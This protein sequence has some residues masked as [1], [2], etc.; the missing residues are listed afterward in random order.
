LKKIGIVTIGQSP[1]DDIIPEMR[2]V[3]GRNVEILERGALDDYTVEEAKR[4]ERKPGE[5]LLVTR[6][7]DGT[8]AGVSHGIVVPLVQKRIEDLE[9]EGVELTLVLCTGRF[10]SFNSKRLIVYP[11]EILRG[12]VSGSI[13]RGRLAIVHPSKEQIRDVEARR[14]Q[15]EKSVWGEEV[16]VIYDAVSPYGPEE[17]VA[18][19]AERLAKAG[20]DLVWLNCMG[21]NSRH[22]EIVKR[23]TGKPVIQ[24]NSLVARVLKELIS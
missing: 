6:L 1:R 13:K 5:G 12:A 15:G 10:P 24:S 14:G 22:K 20:V 11:S 18:E 4:L 7:K 2:R 19:M 8:E 9:K 21:F 17:D 23:K 16:G 3:L